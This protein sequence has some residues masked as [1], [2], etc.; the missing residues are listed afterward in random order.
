MD[1]RLEALLASPPK[2]HNWQGEWCVGG[3]GPVIGR[4]LAQEVERYDDPRAIETGAGLSTLLF[5]LS[6][7]APVTSVA[8]EKSLF[9]WIAAFAEQDGIDVAPLDAKAE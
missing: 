5:L 7:A 1:Q 4:A 9:E 3:L 6:G 8:P 2:L